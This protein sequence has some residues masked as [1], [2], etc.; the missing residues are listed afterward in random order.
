MA[1]RKEKWYGFLQSGT[2]S[3]LT[4]RKR[5]HI[6]KKEKQRRKNPVRDWIEAF[7]W[8]AC[9]V[10]LLNQYLFQAYQIPSSSMMNTLL[11]SD[12]IFVNKLVYGPEL[13]PG[14]MKLP[15]FAEPKR[16][17]VII[18]ESP[19][20]ISRGP[21][22]DIA[23]RIIYMLTFSLVDIDRDAAGNTKPHFLIKRAAAAET[24][25]VRL[26]AG[27]MEIRPAGFSSW[28]TE[29]EFKALAG[30]DHYETR[31]LLEPQNY[32]AIRGGAYAEAYR[33]QEIPLR[34]ADA[35]YAGKTARYRD[36]YSWS[37]YHFEAM[38]KLNPHNRNYAGYWY[39]LKRGWYIP[40][41]W[42]FPLGDNRDNSRD[43]RYFGPV[44]LRNVL[45]E[46]LF[47]YWPPKRVGGIY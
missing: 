5:R 23:Q 37:T 47:K 42:I 40:R 26:T 19:T 14:Q 35:A 22:F 27:D 46:A 43:G 2:E 15:G 39:R 21:L 30:Y 33:T 36:D 34:P 32:E 1:T 6:V 41:G 13:I 24:D 31:R 7:L 18:F 29:G 38:H 11:V 12:R 10:L 20:Y 17:E 28:M 9:V 25:S 45:G 8:A 44:N 4:R 3:L 16:S